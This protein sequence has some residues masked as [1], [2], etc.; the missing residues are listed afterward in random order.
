MATKKRNR[1]PKTIDNPWFLAIDKKRVID[2]K[3]EYKKF[4]FGSEY[5]YENIKKNSNYLKL[6]QLS[7]TDFYTVLK[8][9]FSQRSKKS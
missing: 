5:T 2:T 9:K 8:R 1:E 7:D 6:V 4:D 3:N